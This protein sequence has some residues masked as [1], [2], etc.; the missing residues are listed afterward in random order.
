MSSAPADLE[1]ARFAVGEVVGGTQ[2][3]RD[4][5]TLHLSLPELA[6]GAQETALAEATVDIVRPGD[7]VRIVNVID[8]VVPSVKADDPPATFPGALG[9]LIA[10]GRGRTHVLDGVRV[11]VSCDWSVTGNAEAV[12]FPP[13]FIDMAG[14]SAE[15]APYARTTNVVVTCRP[16]RD[17]TVVEADRAVRRAGLRVARELAATTIGAQPDDVERLQGSRSPA[18][19]LPSVCAVLQ[20]ASEGP[21]VDTFLYGA[22]MGGLVPTLLDPLEV[23]DGALVNGTYDWPSV[24]NATATYQGSPLIR[25]L[26]AADGE[27]LHFAALIVALGYLSTAEDKQRSALQTARLA[28]LI[29]ADAAVCTTF[30]SGNSHTDTMLTVRALESSGIRTCAILAETNGGLTDHVPEADCIVSTGNEDELLEPW[31]P[32]LVIGARDD[33][34]MAGQPVPLSSYLGANDETGAFD[35]TALT[36]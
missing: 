4:A 6:V 2:T 25:E 27:R 1:I 20:V 14:P 29:G 16:S 19:E 18:S 12:E 22:P 34:A 31:T 30:S 15:R 24:R 36:A 5:G 7:P 26:L 32:G 35:L 13:S 11:V 17:A 3:G 23:I 9:T 28:R 8:A 21:L 10:A 33:E